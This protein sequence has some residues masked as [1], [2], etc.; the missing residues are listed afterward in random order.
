MCCC[1]QDDLQ[2]HFS[3]INIKLHVTKKHT[4]YFEYFTTDVTFSL[5]VLKVLTAV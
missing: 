5:E 3:Y 4:L 1:V 2:K